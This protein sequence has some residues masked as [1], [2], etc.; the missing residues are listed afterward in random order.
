MKRFLSI[1]LLILG[2]I[3]LAGMVLTAGCGEETETAAQ[4]ECDFD[5]PSLIPAPGDQPQLVYFFR[6]T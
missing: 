4:I 6:D 3:L 1:P 2:F 5:A